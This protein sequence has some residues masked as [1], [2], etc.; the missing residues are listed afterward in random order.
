MQNFRAKPDTPMAAAGEPGLAELMTACAIARLVMGPAMSIQAPPNLSADY[1]P[2]L[3]AGINDW[4]GVSPL[5][6][7]FVN[8]EAPWPDIDPPRRAHRRR[9]LRAPRA[10]HRLPGVPDATT[11]GSTRTCADTCAPS[12]TTT[13]SPCRAPHPDGGGGGVSVTFCRTVA[14]GAPAGHAR[15]RE[16]AGLDDAAVATAL[17]AGCCRWRPAGADSPPS[18]GS[19]TRT[20]RWSS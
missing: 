12:P 1:G 3:L 7:D 13:A 14:A 15:V 10:A 9:R 19:P 6:P 16:A 2:L 18:P 8:P 4:G 17:A 11:T 20:S 5:T